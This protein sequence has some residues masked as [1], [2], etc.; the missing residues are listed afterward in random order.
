[1]KVTVNNVDQ[2][3]VELVI[4]E[5]QKAVNAAV[6][7]AITNIAKQVN[8]PGFRKGKAPRKVLEMNYG[9]DVILDEAFE[10]LSNRAMNMALAQEKLEPVDTP[11]IEK[12]VFEEGKD[13]EFKVKF[14]KKPEVTLGEYKGLEATK[15]APQVTDEE[16]QEQLDKMLAQQAKM[17]VAPEGTE[18]ATDD[19]AIIDF[20]GKVDGVAFEGGEGKAHPLQIGSNSFIPG[21]EDQLIGAKVGDD[22]EVKVTFPETYFVDE[23]QGKEAI[24]EVHVHDIKRKEQPELT[25]E[26]AKEIS[27]FETV[28]QLKVELRKKMEADKANAAQEK[29][30]QELLDQAVANAT[31][32]I[33]ELMIEQRIDNMIQELD[34]RMAGRGMNVNSFLQMSGKTMEEFREE[35]RTSATKNVKTDLVLETIVDAEKLEVTEDDMRFEIIVMAQ[36]FGADPNE[37]L[38]IIVKEGRVGMLQATVARK[39]AASFIVEHA[40]GGIVE[41]GAAK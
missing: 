41:T 4:T 14:V 15:D 39:K 33:P 23:L 12:V 38:D 11:E 17:V 6:K 31:V 24:F 18:I 9:K 1:M 13:A 22:V 10:L 19:F 36:S 20:L 32:D 29:Y 16:V 21:F 37:V 2:H 3:N 34:M 35:Y 7:T 5:E 25:D 30:N 27:P 28:E 40:K 8:I 26:V